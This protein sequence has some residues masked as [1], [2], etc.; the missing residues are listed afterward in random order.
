LAL[1]SICVPGNP[2]VDMP[3]IV[4]CPCEC[5]CP[6]QNFHCRLESSEHIKLPLSLMRIGKPLRTM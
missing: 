4:A 2:V 1:C 5:E 6:S 3:K